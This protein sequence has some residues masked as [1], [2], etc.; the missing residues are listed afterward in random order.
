MCD[1]TISYSNFHHDCFGH[2]QNAKLRRGW[3][4]TNTTHPI[5]KRGKFQISYFSPVKIYYETIETINLSPSEGNIRFE[6]KF[7]YHNCIGLNL[8]FSY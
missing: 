8:L 6:I 3:K 4:I 7:L 1:S 5:H 2:K